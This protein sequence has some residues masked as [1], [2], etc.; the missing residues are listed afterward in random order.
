MSFSEQTSK[1]VVKSMVGA[2]WKFLER[3]NISSFGYLNATQFLGAMNDN[4]FKLLIAYCFIQ[5]E[6][7]QA[8]NSILAL[9]GAVY[10]IPFLL[11]SQ[12]AGMMADR[13]SKRTIIVS[14]KFIEICVMI[15]G[16]VAFA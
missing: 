6:G 8:S 5:V 16:V 15:I 12:S 13:Y 2:F 11:F 4:I 10:V 7:V 1:S 9:V 14:I 3:L